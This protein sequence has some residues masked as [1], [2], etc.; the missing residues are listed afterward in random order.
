MSRAKDRIT[1]FTN[2][3]LVEGDSLTKQD[4]L[5]N[6]T[7][8]K[9]IR[10]QEEFYGLNRV[11]DTVIDL[12]GRIVA[13]GFIDVQ[14]NGAV[15]FDFS[16]LPDDMAAYSSG[17]RRVNKAL[18]KTGVTSYL[19]TLTS[20]KSEV[21][22][23]S[24]PFLGP[25]GFT[26]MPGDGAESLG[27]HCE[28]PFLSLTKNG[29]HNVEFIQQAPRGFADLEDCYGAGNLRVRTKAPGISNS[30][31]APIKMITAAPEVGSITSTISEIVSRDIVFSIG[32]SE[33]TYE[34]ASKAVEA[35]ATMITHLFNA[36]RPLHHR[37]PGIIGVLGAAGGLPRPFFGVIADGIHLHPTCV[38]LAFNAHPDGCILI[39]DAMSLAGLKDGIYDWTNGD[40]IIKRGALLTLEGSDKLAGSS[41][42]LA[43]CVS[44]FLN[45][46]G[47]TI[48]GAIKTVTSTPAK[49]LGLASTKGT[50]SS[51]ADADIVV[52]SEER[53]ELGYLKL[54]VDQVWKFGVKVHDRHETQY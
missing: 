45:W 3:R 29:V 26:R 33:S 35:G 4:L 34:Q 38:K 37:N 54:N 18:V 1:K 14:L 30:C 53:S 24:L 47:A 50:L 41:A 12:G 39:T 22:L 52:L 23:K 36:M 25:S 31:P 21:Y 51:G 20:Q 48:P 49:M 19:P 28:G 32:H 6:A 10:G 44:N 2:C 7:S 15:G 27:A 46:T 42:T 16:I 17:I 40:R 43:E 13:P 8:G 9:I 5:I 11:P